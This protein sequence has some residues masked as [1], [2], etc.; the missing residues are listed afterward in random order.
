MH[1]G[2]VWHLRTGS[3]ME[4]AITLLNVF[5]NGLLYLDYDCDDISDGVM[6]K[7]AARPLKATR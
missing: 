6:I 1:F 5:Y 3:S 2:I 7:N 4:L